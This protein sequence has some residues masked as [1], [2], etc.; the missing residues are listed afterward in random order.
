MGTK[1]YPKHAQNGR[2][3]Y[4]THDFGRQLVLS[5]IGADPGQVTGNDVIATFRTINATPTPDGRWLYYG[6]GT[7][8]RTTTRPSTSVP[9]P[10]ATA[11][12]TV[13]SAGGADDQ[14]LH[15]S[16]D[17]CVLVLKSNRPG[18]LGGFDLYMA[19]RPK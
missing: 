11:A 14:P 13:L 6:T 2:A 16:S 8:I 4:W 19:T 17:N 5:A 15:I 12:N 18:G 1:P 10:E 9:F 3:L 7:E